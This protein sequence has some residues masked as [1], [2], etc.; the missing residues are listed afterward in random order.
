MPDHT[1]ASTIKAMFIRLLIP[2]LH[3]TVSWRKWRGNSI[4]HCHDRDTWSTLYHSVRSRPRVYCPF[5]CMY[6]CSPIISILLVSPPIG[7]RFVWSVFLYDYLIC[8]HLRSRLLSVPVPLYLL[9]WY[10]SGNRPRTSPGLLI[11]LRELHW[12]SACPTPWALPHTF[13]SSI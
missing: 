9:I 7:E 13:Y 11:V 1:I 5:H 4:Y 8:F 3:T 2:H 6:L 10:T 12:S